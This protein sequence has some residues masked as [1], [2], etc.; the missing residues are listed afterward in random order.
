MAYW[1]RVGNTDIPWL[2]DDEG[3]LRFREIT[4]FW[5]CFVVFVH[6]ILKKF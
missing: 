6:T 3:I 4:M 1:K 5:F 2:T